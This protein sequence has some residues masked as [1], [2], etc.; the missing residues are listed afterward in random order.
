MIY[1]RTKKEPAL[2]NAENSQIYRLLHSIL[3]IREDCKDKVIEEGLVAPISSSKDSITLG[4]MEMELDVPID[5]QSSLTCF[6]TNQVSSDQ[7]RK[8]LQACR[9]IKRTL[10]KEQSVWN[11]GIINGIFF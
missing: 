5:S 6:H 11:G 7:R 1:F 2:S 3:L 4:I 8:I 9:D 10:D